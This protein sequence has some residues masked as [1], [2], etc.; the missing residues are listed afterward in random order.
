MRDI[1]C[2]ARGREGEWEAF[3][4]DFDIAVQGRS[5]N[6]VREAMESAVSEYVAAAREED[7]ATAKRLL[8]RQAPLSVTLLWTARVLMS[9]WRRGANGDTSASF[10]VPCAA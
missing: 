1:L 9:A 10:P 5:F 4:A 6:E 8:S 7:P 3:C 2:F